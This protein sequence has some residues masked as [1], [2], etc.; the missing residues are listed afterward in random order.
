VTW[1]AGDVDFVTALFAEFDPR[2]WLEL[3][4]CGTRRRCG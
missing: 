2:G 1:A 4:T 3:V